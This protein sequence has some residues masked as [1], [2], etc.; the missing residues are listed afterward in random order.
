VPDQQQAVAASERLDAKLTGANPIDILIELPKGAGLYDDR[1]L[2]TIADV[3]A[4]VEKQKGIGNVW[5]VETL[6]RWLIEKA[7]IS[8]VAVLKQ[9]SRFSRST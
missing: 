3:H 4:T 9:M 7:G 1:T 2:Q 6:R 8:D 5:S